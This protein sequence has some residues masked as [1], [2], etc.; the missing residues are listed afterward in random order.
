M[1]EAEKYLQ[2]VSAGL[3]RLPDDEKKEVLS[4]IQTYINDAVKGQ[5][6][7]Q[8]VLDRLGPPLRLA[9]SYVSIH[10]VDNDNIGVNTVV[11]N[12][13]FYFS[14]GLASIIILPILFFTAFALILSSVIVVAYAVLHLF[15]NLPGGSI[16][17]GAWS[18]TGIP[19]VI[20]AII[21]GVIFFYLAYLLWRLLRKYIAYISLRYQKRR[22]KSK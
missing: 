15:F 2:R 3:Y 19:A 10:N 21:C 4:E 11:G 5:E 12:I 22:L 14:A 8:T 7:I 6:P 20:V 18:F 16:D 1:N 17:L 13:A 9:Q